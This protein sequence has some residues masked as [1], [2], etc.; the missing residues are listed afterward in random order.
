MLFPASRLLRTSLVIATLAVLSGVGNS[1]EKASGS[2][3]DSL[4]V[5]ELRAALELSQAEARREKQRADEAEARRRAAAESLAEAVRVSEE[6][7]A[8]AHE[9]E[10]KLQALGMAG[11][12]G[13]ANSLDQRLLKAV[14][15]LDISGQDLEAHREA[16]RNL[17]ETFLKVLQEQK[18]LPK[19]LRTEADRALAKAGEVMAKTNTGAQPGATDLTD[20]RVVSIDGGIGLVVFDAGRRTGLRVGT[21]VAILRGEAPLFSALVVD[22]RDSISGAVLQDRMAANGEVEVGDRVRLL[23]EQNTF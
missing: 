13:E 21:P 18:D 2:A 12:S 15:D 3:T 14:R 17:S 4:E 1:Q 19:G 10:L 22:V 5:R 6:Q 9:S 11:I 16:L 20:S 7:L 23:P 8:S